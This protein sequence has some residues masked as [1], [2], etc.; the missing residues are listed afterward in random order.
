MPAIN[1]KAEYAP[2]ILNGSKP[3]TLRK[4]RADFRDP[5]PEGSRLSL[6]TGMRTKSCTKFASAV[7]A[8][9]GTIAFN[10]SGL[11]LARFDDFDERGLVDEHATDHERVTLATVI[12]TM[13][14]AHGYPNGPRAAEQ[15]ERIAVWDG[16]SSWADMWAFHE[17]YGVNA[18]GVALRELIGFGHVTSTG[19]L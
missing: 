3:F 19:A 7:C 10:A 17:A 1:F 2:K 11:V 12:A 4:R 14:N 18:D 15:R 5:A 16:F 9:R 6:F 13:T 8:L